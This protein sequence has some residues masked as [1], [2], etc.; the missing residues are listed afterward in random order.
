M[1]FRNLAK[2]VVAACLALAAGGPA[3]FAQY[4]DPGA[5][6]VPGRAPPGYGS[7]RYQERAAPRYRVAPQYG[8]RYQPAPPPSGFYFPWFSPAPQPAYQPEPTYRPQRQRAAPREA[9]RPA[10]R[11]TPAA[12]DKAKDP[13]TFVVTFGDSLAD[14]V[15]NGLI[16]V[17]E[18]NPDLEIVSKTRGDTGLARVDHYDWPK[19]IGDV[20]A[21]DQKITFAVVMLGAND[22][23]SIREGEVSHDPLSDR[24]REIYRERVD[25]V[26]KPFV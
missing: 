5:V 19:A 10:P 13:S 26:L 6:Y 2:V 17:F 4:Y 16:E 8:G 11:E 7:P 15:G 1:R 9:R 18:D 21:S 14:H 25:A 23:Q 12:A 3:A 20:L 24:W 22:R